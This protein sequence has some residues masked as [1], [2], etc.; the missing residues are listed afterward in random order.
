MLC[1]AA[2]TPRGNIVYAASGRVVV[3]SE[4][5][6]VI[7]THWRIKTPQLLSIS[8]DDAIYLTDW[9]TGVYQSTDDGFSWSIVFNSADGWRCIQAIKMISDHSDDFWMLEDNGN[10]EYH[11]RVYS[12]DRRH[13]DSNVMWMD[14]KITATYGIDIDLSRIRMSNYGN[15]NIFLNDQC[16]K[17]VHMLS[18]NNQYHCQ[19][20]PPHRM[21]GTPW[22]VAVDKERELLYVGQDKRVVV[23]KLI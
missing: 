5:G 3:M 2:W 20:I 21:K 16:N 23:F 11:L 4:S 18:M 19:L 9:N 8:N 17:A 15:M 13:S 7:T 6:N 22:R 1:D 12:V 10:N 14:K